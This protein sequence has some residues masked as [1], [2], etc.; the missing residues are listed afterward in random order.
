MS[1]SFIALGSNLNEP[2]QQLNQA[3]LALQALPE[4]EIIAC[5]SI[6]SG[7]ALTLDGE[8][9]NDYLNAVIE[10]QTALDPLALLDRLQA[11]EHSQGRRREK[12]WGARSLDLDILLV[13][14]QIINSA[15]LTL[16]HYDMLNRD[17]V[18]IPLHQ[19]APSLVIPGQTRSLEDFIAQLKESSLKQLGEFDG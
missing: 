2:L 11:I 13:D 3:K 10:I 14:Q 8:A 17:F 19:I 9:Q 6:Y 1:Q 18:L 15:R 16:P 7:P 12:R 4:T 5:S